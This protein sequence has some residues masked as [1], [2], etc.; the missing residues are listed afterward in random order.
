MAFVQEKTK[1]QYLTQDAKEEAD[2]NLTF[3]TSDW[4]SKAATNE[5][6][7]EQAELQK[8]ISRGER[9]EIIEGARMGAKKSLTAR[10]NTRIQ[11]E[12]DRRQRVYE[13][14]VAAEQARYERELA[15]YNKQVKLQKEEYARELAKYNKAV[16]DQ[17]AAIM[18]AQ[19]D[20]GGSG[21]SSGGKKKSGNE[22]RRVGRAIA[23]AFGW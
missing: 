21:S 4:K 23:R 9:S 6:K 20:Q 7:I 11:A 12:N 18:A 3:Y 2:R 10:E 14:Q 8:A 5:A 1:A 22:F 13:A 19:Q 15:D 16:A 17:R